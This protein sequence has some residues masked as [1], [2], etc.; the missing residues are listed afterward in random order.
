MVYRMSDVPSYKDPLIG[1]PTTYREELFGGTLWRTV[2]HVFTLWKSKYTSVV[3]FKNTGF[4]VDMAHG[5]SI[6]IHINFA[7]VFTFGQVIKEI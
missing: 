2:S 7:T 3:T 4:T 1:P 6:G 5:S